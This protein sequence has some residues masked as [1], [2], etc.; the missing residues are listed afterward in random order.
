M[1]S[2][3]LSLGFF[4]FAITVDGK[5]DWQPC[6]AA[7]SARAGHDICST[8][9]PVSIRV[10]SSTV[11][12]SPSVLPLFAWKRLGKK[13]RTANAGE[14]GS[15]LESAERRREEEREREREGEREGERR[16]KGKEGP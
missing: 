6:C 11:S 7:V 2:S 9:T 13:A 15:E 10:D 4:V 14:K 8:C 3:L 16:A 5:R 1:T 12:T